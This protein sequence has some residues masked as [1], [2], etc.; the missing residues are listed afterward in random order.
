MTD[1]LTNSL[2]E[3]RTKS[4]NDR[5]ALGALESENTDLR[6]ELRRKGGELERWR[7]EVQEVE[8]DREAIVEREETRRVDAVAQAQE[9]IRTAAEEQFAQAQQMF[10]QLKQD[11]EVAVNERDEFMEKADAAKKEGEG[12]ERKQKG[13]LAA[14]MAELAEARAELA[15]AQA[16]AMKLK[17]TY[18]EK[19]QKLID[20]ENELEERLVRVEKECKETH[21]LVGKVVMEKDGLKVEN[22]ELQNVCEELMGMVEGSKRK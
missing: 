3:M 17:Q 21:Q 2:T 16:D 6:E 15:T 8:K 11:Y 22:Q 19:M 1:A 12:K 18:G 4:Y 9:E 13:Q 10:F 7:V 5:N 14:L 20:R